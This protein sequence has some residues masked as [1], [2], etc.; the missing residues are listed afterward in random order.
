[1]DEFFA[2]KSFISGVA[3]EVLCPC[4]NSTPA[5]CTASDSYTSSTLELKETFI[6]QESQCS[7]HGVRIDVKYRG[8][9]PSW[10]KPFTGLRLTFGDCATNLGD[11]V[12]VF[13]R[14]FVFDPSGRVSPRLLS[15]VN[16]DLAR[17]PV[18]Q[19]TV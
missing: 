6:T 14:L 1:M 3:N 13:R 11:S 9:I 18:I 19:F 16:F 10:W 8:E 17:R 4:Y 12:Q 5:T 2:T 15:V 7:K